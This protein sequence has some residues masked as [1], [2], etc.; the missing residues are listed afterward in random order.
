MSSVLR[1]PCDA[2]ANRFNI[3]DRIP[4]SSASNTRSSS[5]SSC[6][7][8]ACAKAASRSHSATFFPALEAAASTS[9]NSASVSL[10]AIDLPRALSL[11]DKPVGGEAII[12]GLSGEEAI[13]V[14][15]GNRRTLKLG[16]RRLFN[17][18]PLFARRFFIVV[19]R[20]GLTRL[21]TETP[22]ST[23]VE[24]KDVPI[25]KQNALLQFPF[26]DDVSA[27]HPLRSSVKVR[28]LANQPSKGQ[29]NTK[30]T[31]CVALR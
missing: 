18:Y 22:E 8:R 19:S 10:V 7:L 27:L 24:N 31:A 4:I 12:C 28:P 30:P 9:L 2:L 13:E 6:P 20:P 17:R 3:R 1:G 26:G 14:P 21:Q 29:D 11:P 16:C 23:C 25:C 5:P 15:F